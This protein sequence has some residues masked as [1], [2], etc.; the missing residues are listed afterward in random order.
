M[1]A[2]TLVK[3]AFTHFATLA[4]LAGAFVYLIGWSY[5]SNYFRYFGLSAIEL[6]ISLDFYIIYGLH[7]LINYW[8]AI[9][10]CIF[11]YSVPLF[12]LWKKNK[13]IL[14]IASLFLFS[15]SYIGAYALGV[16]AANNDLYKQKKESFGAFP[17]IRIWLKK[18]TSESIPKSI[19]SNLKDAKYRLLFKNSEHI[20]LINTE[21]L[22]SIPVTIIPVSAVELSRII[23][24]NP[25]YRNIYKL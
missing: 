4:A 7:S 13:D 17:N 10:F 22:G 8:P 11:L 3:T 9:V 6:N 21:N 18:D 12:F 23:P 5:A 25:A 1:T 16:N 19:S 14:F 15:T 20:Y 2:Q 24:R